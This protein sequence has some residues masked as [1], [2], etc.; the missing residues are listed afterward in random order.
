MSEVKANVKNPK[1]LQ[2]TGSLTNK[3]VLEKTS[4]KMVKPLKYEVLSSLFKKMKG[5]TRY[6]VPQ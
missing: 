4:G 5:N 2:A 3:E 1:S 6:L